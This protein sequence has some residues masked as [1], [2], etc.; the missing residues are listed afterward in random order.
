MIRAAIPMWI[1]AR[2]IVRAT[3]TPTRSLSSWSTRRLS[4][5]VR[6][7]V[8]DNSKSTAHLRR[9]CIGCNRVAVVHIANS[10]V[11]RFKIDD[12]AGSADFN[13]FKRIGGRKPG[14]LFPAQMFY[15]S[16]FWFHKSAVWSVLDSKS[17][18]L[19]SIWNMMWNI[20]SLD[21]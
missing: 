7:V 19:L 10:E 11:P 3:R 6:L 12:P 13:R 8:R 14:L 20:L 21:I 15:R 17:M 18:R 1:I 5:D 9:R 2:I 16:I 4:R